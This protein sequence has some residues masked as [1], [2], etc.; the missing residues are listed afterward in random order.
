M[1]RWLRGLALVVALGVGAGAGAPGPPE[2]LAAGKGDGGARAAGETEAAGPAPRLDLALIE[3]RRS[4]AVPWDRLDENGYALVRDVVGAALVA[5]E[6]RDIAFRSR[7]EVFD[8]LLEHPDFAA[9]VARVVREGTY[10]VR[11]VGEGF[12]AED[13]R[14]AHG[15]FRTLA[16]DGGLRVFHLAGRYEPPLLPTVAGSMVL[17]LHNEHVEGPDGVTYCAVTIAGYVRMDTFAAEVLAMVSRRL[18]ESYVDRKVRR[19]FRHVAALSRR[20]YDD[21]EGL[22]AALARRPDL[23]PDRLAEFTR[24]LLAPVRPAWADGHALGLLDSTAL[25]SDGPAVAAVAFP[26]GA[27]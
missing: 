7:R 25:W 11:R 21:P 5:R 19:F 24:L 2:A 23:P 27:E 16:V 26:P 20:A 4:R 17:L 15:T 1:M 10:R 14:G 3:P 18:T 8:F 12:V 9:E 6:V 22:A 13:G